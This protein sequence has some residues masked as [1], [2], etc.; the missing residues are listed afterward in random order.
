[1]V[2]IDQSG[3]ICKIIAKA[4]KYRKHPIQ[5]IV[6]GDF[7][8][9]PPII[10]DKEKKILIKKYKTSTGYAYEH[11]SWQL[12]N[13]VKCKLTTSL[14]AKQD[15]QYVQMLNNLRYKRNLKQVIAY[16]NK[17]VI[18]TNRIKDTVRLFATNRLVDKTNNQCLKLLPGKEVVIPAYYDNE[19]RSAIKHKKLKQTDLPASLL[20]TIKPNAQIMFIKN[21]KQTSNKPRRF[22]NGDMGIVVRCYSPEEVVCRVNRTNK[23]VRLHKYNLSHQVNKAPKLILGAIVE[24]EYTGLFK[25]YPI[26]LVYGLTIHKAQGKTFA[27]VIFDPSIDKSNLTPRLIYVALSRCISIDNLFLAKPLSLKQVE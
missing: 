20:L 16:F 7:Y 5:L 13:F 24:D 4:N 2:R 15:K 11:P 1:M 17:R 18:K 26:K 3:F 22:V 23:L 25:Q 21:D 27:N 14:R 9:L 8:Q 12:A 10:T 6:S 19:I